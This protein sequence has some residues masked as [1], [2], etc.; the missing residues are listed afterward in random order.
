VYN[1]ANLSKTSE[2][3]KSVRFHLKITIREVL[4]M[5]T[6]TSNASSENTGQV[7]YQATQRVRSSDALSV[8]ICTKSR[9]HSVLECI[10]SARNQSSQPGE[11]VIVDASDEDELEA[12]LTKNYGAE[13]RVKYVR[14]EGSLPYTRNIGVRESSGDILLFLDDDIVLTKDFIKEILSVFNDPNL[15][16]IGCVYGNQFLDDE[17]TNLRGTLRYSIGLGRRTEAFIRELFFLQKTSKTGKFRLSGFSTY[18]AT[19]HPGNTLCKTEGAAGA[20]MAYNREVLNEF[21]FDENLEGY[22]WGEDADL[23]YRVSRKYKVIF[24]PKA[25]AFHDSKT[26]KSANYAYSKMRIVHHH[27]LFKKNFPQ[28]LRNHFAFNMSVLGLFFLELQHALWL[29]DLQGVRGFLDG[30]HAAHKKK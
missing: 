13:P 16:L 25:K 4:N 6:S 26:K 2:L 5:T 17:I 30:L 24:N 23:S 22:A 29:R 21:K 15:D 28:A 1:T 7:L 12:L 3:H 11:I 27:Y 9:P 8:I 10:E 14:S 18:M 20:Y 19:S